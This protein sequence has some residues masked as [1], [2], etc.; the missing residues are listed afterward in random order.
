[1]ATT[2]LLLEAISRRAKDFDVIHAHVDWLHL[3]LLRRLGVPYLT[4]MHGRLDLP[5]LPDVIR[6]F[7]EASFISIPD[8]QRLPFLNTY[9]TI[10]RAPEPDFRQILED[11]RVLRFAA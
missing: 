3:P 4:T 2:A 10:C 1:M 5:G 9:R 11:V 6:E 8:N 7:P